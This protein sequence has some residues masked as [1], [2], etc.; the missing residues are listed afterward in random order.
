[1]AIANQTQRI[2]NIR[3]CI[4]SLLHAAEFAGFFDK[5]VYWLRSRRIERTK[6][7]KVRHLPH[8]LAGVSWIGSVVF[9]TSGAFSKEVMFI[10]VEP[11]DAA[12]LSVFS[13][14]LICRLVVRRLKLVIVAK[15]GCV[16]RHGVLVVKPS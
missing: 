4:V 14:V 3:S 9:P 5:A 11:F 6:A 10:S 15:F 7:H 12:L 8:K 2:A 1:M 13:E 16:F